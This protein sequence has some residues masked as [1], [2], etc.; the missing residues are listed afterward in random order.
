MKP[1]LLWVPLAVLFVATRP[2]QAQAPRR[3]ADPGPRPTAS[4]TAASQLP[5]T[6]AELRAASRQPMPPQVLFD[7][8]QDGDVW[9]VGHAWKARFDG[10]GFDFIPFFGSQAPRN[11]PLRV[12]LDRVTVGG[13][14]LPLTAGVPERVDRSIRTV[15]GG[16]TEVVATTLR[17]VEQA[18]VFDTLPNRGD[19]EVAVRFTGDFATEAD[20]DGLR[21]V[22]EHGSFTYDQAIAIDA[23]GARL[24]LPITWMGTAAR[25]VV[26]AVFVAEARLPLVLDPLLGTVT[27]IGGPTTQL[28]RDPD[29]A[30]LQNPD[31]TCVVWEREWSATDHDIWAQLYDGAM[32]AVGSSFAIDATTLD[33]R[34][35]AVAGNEFSLSFL[36]VGQVRAGNTFYIAG[37]RIAGTSGVIGPQFDIERGGLVGHFP[38][39]N[40]RPD[41]GGDF[42]P[43]T[44]AY[45]C[46][47]W[48]HETTGSDDDIVFKLV[49]QDGT[50]TAPT[51]LT[52]ADG[53]DSNPCIA[54]Q[55]GVPA[56]WFVA[57]QSTYTSPPFDQDIKGAFITWDGFLTG[58]PFNVATSLANDTLPA[59][60]SP[61]R[62]GASDRWLVAY[63][64]DAAGARDILCSV[65]D[66]N[67]VWHAGVNLNAL[68]QGGAYQA[69]DQQRPDCDSDGVRFVV[70][71]TEPYGGSADFETRV[72]TLAYLIGTATLTIQ[73]ERRGLGVST[74][75]E[76]G[77]RICS[78]HS[79]GG[80]SDAQFM[81]VDANWTDNAIDLYDYGGWQSGAQ[82]S[83]VPTAC[84][85]L[86]ITYSGSTQVGSTLT[87]TVPHGALSGTVFGDPGSVP[88]LP[89]F[90]CNCTLGVSTGYF[91]G[92][93]LVFTIPPDPSFVGT[94]LAVQGWT[95]LGST[96]LGFLD[97]SDTVQFVVR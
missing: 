4:P 39:N 14:A 79:G 20:A 89:F 67:G 96:C 81:V 61:I 2:C 37:R 76:Y 59:T 53:Q 27:G 55:C 38:G 28:Q 26:P 5:Q 45:W 65:F 29:V 40:Y 30:T 13:Q 84:G 66:A 48:Q 9:A 47:V 70:G 88:L 44:Q 64:N 72:S 36:A 31:R 42:F 33:W 52:Y 6:R 97:L 85:P 71:Y 11:F 17:A 62:A 92:N 12:E 57:Y 34:E 73:D 7:R 78:R 1:I 3:E 83:V 56:R 90:G 43:S 93:P 91:M 10:R 32:S 21:F 25:I 74:D 94:V 46:V 75:D 49:R 19:I 69:Y 51:F 82:F 54:K 86:S 15:R 16:L 24:A 68:E 8:T 41:V 63:E 58:T 22:N 18:W 77:T 87:F 23:G 35:P 80:V 60:S 95:A 50:L